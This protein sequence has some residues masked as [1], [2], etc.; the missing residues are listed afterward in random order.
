MQA[1]IPFSY[2]AN[3]L[4]CS[5]ADRPDESRKEFIRNNKVS[6][7]GHCP[8]DDIKQVIKKIVTIF[9][10][11]MQA[12]FA[13]SHRQVIQ[14]MELKLPVEVELTISQDL[15]LVLVAGVEPNANLL[16]VLYGLHGECYVPRDVAAVWPKDEE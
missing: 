11:Y 8:G 5:V 15:Y 4:I 3:I 2:R 13:T 7:P 12:I 16:L 9:F 10:L 14:A 6:P 1:L